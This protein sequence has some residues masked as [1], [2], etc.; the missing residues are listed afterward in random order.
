MIVGTMPIRPEDFKQHEARVASA[1]EACTG[2]HVER[3]DV[4]RFDD[5][6]RRNLTR[7]TENAIRHLPDLIATHRTRKHV[8]IEC[9]SVTPQYEDSPNYTL[10]MASFDA[11]ARWA[12]WGSPVLIVWHDLSAT[13]PNRIPW[14]NPIEGPRLGRGSDDR[15]WLIN[16][17]DLAMVSQPLTYYLQRLTNNLW[18][19]MDQQRLEGLTP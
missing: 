19:E 16:R 5:T 15:Y 10:E 14:I 1:I 4:A 18:D 8:L 11:C 13:R 17:R 2:W 3:F 7:G 9:K 12:S 6:T